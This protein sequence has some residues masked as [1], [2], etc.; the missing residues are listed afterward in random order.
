MRTSIVKK[1]LAQDQ[2]ILILQLHI[3]DPSIFEFASLMGFDC[4]WMDLEHHGYSLETANNL[5]R[6]T[7]VGNADII[8]RPGKGEFMLIKQ[9]LERLRDGASKVGFQFGPSPL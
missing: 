4:I 2:P 9:G 8:A 1:K 7:R 6:A 5:M 3:I